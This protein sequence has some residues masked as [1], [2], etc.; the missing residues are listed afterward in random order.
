MTEVHPEPDPTEPTAITSELPGEDVVIYEFEGQ[1]IDKLYV[2]L[3]GAKLEVDQAFAR[4]TYLTLKVEYRVRNIRMEEDRKGVFSRHAVL[5]L[6][7]DAAIV[8]IDTAEDRL[9]RAVESGDAYYADDESEDSD[10]R[11]NDD[12]ADEPAE[13]WEYERP[14][15]QLDEPTAEVTSQSVEE[16]FV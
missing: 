11:P 9:A 10:A 16:I 2:Q 6:D 12:R 8:S 15:G 1:P 5:V 3:P 4:N 14:D 7:G 13:D